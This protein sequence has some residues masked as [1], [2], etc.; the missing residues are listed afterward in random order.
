[1]KPPPIGALRHRVVLESQTRTP[2]GGGGAV[3]AWQPV[4]ELWAAVRP[5][6][7]REI[8]TGEAISSRVTHAVTIR[9]RDSIGPTMR[10]RL[11]DRILAITAVLD[12]DERRR[13]LECHCREEAS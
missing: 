11:D 1:M 7:G 3:L 6:A 5:L 13:F 4:A 8:V 12:V 2:D 10:F 9:H